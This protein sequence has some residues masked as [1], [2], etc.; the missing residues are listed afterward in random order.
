[1][2]ETESSYA[3]ITWVL[4]VPDPGIPNRIIPYLHRKQGTVWF[5]EPQYIDRFMRE[6]PSLPPGARSRAVVG[7]DRLLKLAQDLIRAG[8]NTL[9]YDLEYGKDAPGRSLPEFA[10]R[11]R[12]QLQASE[13]ALE[14][15]SS[16]RSIRFRV[17]T[18]RK[19]G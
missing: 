3:D 14:D 1:M 12:E 15:A 6:H 17:P 19:P 13:T 7:R 2:T 5:S 10:Q 4:C 9:Y 18:A 16:A 8:V 11:L